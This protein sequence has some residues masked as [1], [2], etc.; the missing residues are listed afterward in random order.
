MVD[1]GCKEDYTSF[2]GESLPPINEY[3]IGQTY[4]E[5][6]KMEKD[7]SIIIQDTN[8]ESAMCEAKER[9]W[10]YDYDIRDVGGN[11]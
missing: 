9:F 3:D 1:K 4:I 11:G 8:F 7:V 2:I 5:W 10:D 6:D